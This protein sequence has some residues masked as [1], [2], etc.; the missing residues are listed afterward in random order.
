[1][2]GCSILEGKDTEFAP[3]PNSYILIDKNKN[4]K[5]FSNLNK[6]STSLKKILIKFIFLIL[7]L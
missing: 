7:N 4:M 3:I 1:M 6:I 5:F 2:L